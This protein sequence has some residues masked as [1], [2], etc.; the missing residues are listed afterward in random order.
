M[1]VIW[2]IW[3]YNFNACNMEH[4]AIFNVCNMEHMAIFNACNMEHMAIIIII[5]III[6]FSQATRVT[7]KA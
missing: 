3:L 4:M 6:N 2:S 1:H 5:I 7:Q